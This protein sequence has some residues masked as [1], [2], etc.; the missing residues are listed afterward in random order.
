MRKSNINDTIK[1]LRKGWSGEIGIHAHDNLG[2]AL[3]N[4]L[5]AIKEG[6]SWVNS[7]VMGMGRGAGNTQT[8]IS[9]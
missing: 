2:L 7:T 3:S 1:S 6:V 8:N 4:T 5:N 9:P